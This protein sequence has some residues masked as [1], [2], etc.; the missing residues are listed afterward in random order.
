MKQI[1][2]AALYADET[3]DYRMPENPRA[4]EKVSFRFRAAHQDI[5]HIFMHIRYQ[6]HRGETGGLPE[7][8]DVCLSEQCPEL[9]WERTEHGF[10]WFM[11][12]YTLE[13]DS[14]SYLFEVQGEE[15]TC[16]FQRNGVTFGPDW[17][18][19]FY[20]V[21][22]FDVPQWAKGAVMYQI[23]TDRFCNG[24][25]ANDVVDG[26]YFYN[27]TQVSG[28][29]LWNRNP[30][31]NLVGEFYGGDLKGVMDK[32][33]YLKE[34]GVEALYFN[35]LFVSPSYHKYDT[36]DYDYIDPH[37]GVIVKDEGDRLT[38][39]DRDNSHATRYKTRVTD[40]ENLKATNELFIKLVRESHKRGI[41][42]I[43]DGVFN[44]CGSFHKWLDRE[45]LYSGQHG[46]EAGAYE[47]CDSPYH[48]YFSFREGSG[49]PDN[50]NYEGWWDFATLPKLNYEGSRKL[51]EEI[52][53]I[54]EKWIS[55]PFNVDGWRL[56]VAADLGHGEAFNHE[57]WR[58]FRRRIKKVN[59]DA[60]ILA[61]HYGSPKAW[62]AGDQWDTVM[63][64]DAFMEPVSYFFTGMEKHSDDYRPEL[65]GN[66]EYFQQTMTENMS[67]F[68]ADS[69][70]SAMNQLSNHDHSRFLT[71]TNHKVGRVANLGHKAASENIDKSVMAMAVVLQMTWPGAPSLYYGDEAGVCGFTDPDSRRTYPW[72]NEDKELLSL[73][74]KAIHLHKECDVLRTGSFCFLNCGER[75]GILG[76]VRFDCTQQAVVLIN[77]QQKHLRGL[78]SLKEAGICED[79][80]AEQVFYTHGCE[81][82]T[83]PITY[84]IK[85]GL[86]D[87]SLPAHSTVILYHRW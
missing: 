21:P 43:L 37:F 40:R 24:D 11:T 38:P 49:W 73:Y 22:G 34:L 15:E 75:Y 62:L 61:E 27:G 14:C 82:S 68:M 64:Y 51:Q 17:D 85:Q 48:D 67:N 66:V 84:E 50:G 80:S 33:D 29:Q 16:F 13:G 52:F 32:L 57:F 28:V 35:P 71:R 31:T 69:L 30:S 9:V 58:E 59:P 6:E 25:T 12:Q 23:F 56:D 79:V 78:V 20:Y 55:P 77:S 87:I 74:R 45:K 8:G 3:I 4:G 53:R 54:G 36:Q 46:Y 47:A 39:G 60:L 2:K 7:G 1:D 42:V 63:N 44:H 26:E 72:G 81:V 41:R 5:R 76:F 83:V 86:L 18:H 19:A 70:L 65:C 10:D